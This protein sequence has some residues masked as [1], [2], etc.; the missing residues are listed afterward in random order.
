MGCGWEG[1]LPIVDYGRDQMKRIAI[2][3]AVVAMFASTATIALAEDGDVDVDD[4]AEVRTTEPED[5]NEA[6]TQKLDA[7][8]GFLVADPAADD[9]A[10]DAAKIEIADLSYDDPA[11]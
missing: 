1:A 8:A 5:F 11:T 6:E 9:D 7:L 4:D 10:L 2:L 3:L